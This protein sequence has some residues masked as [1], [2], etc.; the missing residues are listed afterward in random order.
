MIKLNKPIYEVIIQ[1]TKAMD[2]VNKMFAE[3]YKDL[4]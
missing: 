3:A 4:K 1:D 2:A